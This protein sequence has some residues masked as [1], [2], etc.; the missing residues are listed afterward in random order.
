MNS[1]IFLNM[2]QK[3]WVPIEQ[4]LTKCR[5][6]SNG[7]SHQSYTLNNHRIQDPINGI[8]SK[9]AKEP[10][11]EQRPE[12]AACLSASISH[13][14]GT[15]LP[16]GCEFPR[17]NA[18]HTTAGARPANEGH[19]KEIRFCLLSEDVPDLCMLLIQRKDG[20]KTREPVQLPWGTTDAHVLV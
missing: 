7:L 13:Q 20:I 12:A 19:F 10:E 4:F 5:V 8:N 1:C 14:R 3:L 16:V 6:H 2:Q 15:Q 18:Y 11:K 9:R 17:C